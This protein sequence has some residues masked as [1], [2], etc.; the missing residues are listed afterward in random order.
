MNRAKSAIRACVEHVFGCMTTTMAMGGKPT[1]KI[2]LD[3]R[4]LYI[5][6]RAWYGLKNLSFNLLR[7]LQG[8]W[9]MALAA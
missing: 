6:R 2:G 8:C 3:R 7:Y 4:Q 5:Q 9:N 1:R